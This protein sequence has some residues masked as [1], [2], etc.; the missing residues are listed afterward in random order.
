MVYE[1]DKLKSHW[2]L[3]LENL[4]LGILTNYGSETGRTIAII[5]KYAPRTEFIYQKVEGAGK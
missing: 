1:L 4:L 2:S 3:H 5:L